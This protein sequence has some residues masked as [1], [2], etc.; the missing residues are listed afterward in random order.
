VFV[1]KARPGSKLPSDRGMY[2]ITCRT[3]ERV[4]VML[5][6][7]DECQLDKNGKGNRT[8]LLPVNTLVM[9]SKLL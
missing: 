8:G 2:R 3:P 6:W 7:L 9:I 5:E 1:A 4:K